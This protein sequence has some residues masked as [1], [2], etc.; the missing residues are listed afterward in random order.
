MNFS[1]LASNAARWL[2][3]EE[4]SEGMVI[5]CRARLA[6]NISTISFAPK[7]TIDDQ[8]LVI[9]RVMSAAQRSRHM[10]SA[11]FFKM[12]AL[13]ANERRLLVERH[14]I[15]PA[16]AESKG[17][18]GVLFSRDEAL[19]IMIN[20]EDHLRL[21][22]ILPGLQSAAAWSAVNALDDELG[23]A[24]EYA[25]SD[26]W[27]FLTA[28]PTN[29]GT[30]LRVS[31]LIH[32]PALVL[33]EDMERVT[34][35]LTQMTFTVRGFYGEGTNSV[36]NL[37]QISNQS[38]LGVEEGEIVEKLTSIT[39]QI[40]AHEK[41]AQEALLKEAPSQVEDKV[42]R[43][44]GLLAHARVLSSQEFMNLL[45]A[46]RLGRSLNLIKKIDSGFMNRL[47]IITQ[48]SHL[49]AERG[50]D[51]TAEE[52]DMYRAELVRENFARLPTDN[53]GAS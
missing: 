47:M 38:T 49:Q 29:V 39:Q 34:R 37:F 15:S 53:A 25:H 10:R 35:G 12:N 27:G 11:A 20:E 22:A 3:G 8:E 45:S 6:R 19:S 23:T 4:D 44:Y 48:P 50:G 18:R 30:G 24:L 51:L 32:L 36:G 2:S 42:W 26:D 21:Q 41:D 52:R 7:A 16:L 40:I 14:L 13:Q 17:Q 46:V 9:D 5:S 33:T 31:V 43:A 1:E 28:C